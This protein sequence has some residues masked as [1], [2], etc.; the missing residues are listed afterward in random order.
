[1]NQTKQ[2]QV[3]DRHTQSI[4]GTYK[5]RKRATNKADKLDNIYGAYRYKVKSV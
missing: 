1:M 4:I 3:I 5:S 2:Y